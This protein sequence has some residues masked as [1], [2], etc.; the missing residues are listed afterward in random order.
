MTVTKN[1]I[2]N[3]AIIIGMTLTFSG[4]V[5]AENVTEQCSE[6]CKL[7]HGDYQYCMKECATENQ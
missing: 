6:S 7:Y 3:A 2:L 5:V 4:A 1:L